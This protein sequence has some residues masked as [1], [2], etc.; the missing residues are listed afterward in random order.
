MMATFADK[1]LAWFDRHGRKDLPWQQ[2]PTPYR[3][4]VSE[5][6][7]QQTQVT[8]VIPYYA[9]FMQRFPNVQALADA[10][11]DD[12]LKLWEGLGYYSRAR[13]LHKTAQQVCDA[14]AGVFPTDMPGMETLPGIGRSTAAAILSLCHGQ[15]EAILD[16]NVKRVL[17]RYHAVAGWAGEPRVQKQLWAYAEQHL[18]AER[19][20]AYTQAMM[21]MGAT[22]CTRSKPL[23]LLCPLQNGCQ[24]FKQGKPQAYPGKRPAKALP[25]KTALALLLRNTAGELL[26]QQRPPTGVWGGLW[27]FPEFADETALHDWLA[28]HF[29]PTQTITTR[30]PVLTHTFSHYRLHLQPLQVDLDAQPAR[31]MEG[32]GW[33]WYKANTEY[34]GGLSAA[35]RQFFQTID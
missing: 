33:L 15:R 6:M 35:V 25:E 23:C 14:Y 5:I 13:N 26:L 9:R 1:V 30:L 16:G 29:A 27:S 32:N 18:P 17:A 22:L 19:N 24:A 2:K 10:P 28:Q 34:T 12:V 7:L 4:W 3:V 11:P 20:A 31:I 21:D 8:T